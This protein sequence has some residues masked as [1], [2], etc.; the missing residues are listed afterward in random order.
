MDAEREV[1]RVALPLP[2]KSGA[3]V[4]VLVLVEPGLMGADDSVLAH[5]DI[6][7]DERWSEE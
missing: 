4:A 2:S 5:D 6:L 3:L 1:S 7:A